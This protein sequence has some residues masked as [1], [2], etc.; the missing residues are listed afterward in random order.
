MPKARNIRQGFPKNKSQFC[1]NF[2]K[3]FEYYC[4]KRRRKNLK[5]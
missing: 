3:K 5:L 1:E 4:K 2:A